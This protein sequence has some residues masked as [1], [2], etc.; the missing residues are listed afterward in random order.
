MS[1]EFLLMPGVTTVV[2]NAEG[3]VINDSI[4][5]II[6]LEPHNNPHNSRGG[7]GV[8]LTEIPKSSMTCPRCHRLL[9]GGRGPEPVASP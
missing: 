7:L 9:F 5:I 4:H 2:I 8:C 3:G 1:S 6:S